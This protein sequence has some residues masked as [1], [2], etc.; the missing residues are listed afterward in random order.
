MITYIHLIILDFGGDIDKTL[1]SLQDCD[2]KDIIT[3]RK[4]T[5]SEIQHLIDRD[6]FITKL[7]GV[8]TIEKEINDLVAKTDSNYI[9]IINS[10]ETVDN[11]VARIEKYT[12]K[13]KISMIRPVP[14]G[15]NMEGQLDFSLNKLLVNSPT[16]RWFCG[17]GAQ[18]I[19][20]KVE[21]QAKNEGRE[22][23]TLNSIEDLDENS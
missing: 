5:T 12:E 9:F 13:K 20:E 6:C 22:D 14:Y 17:F 15:Y 23:L 21:I 10:G 2:T 4:L 18:T 19:M 11:L 8:Q 3:K 1:D 16:W 7:T